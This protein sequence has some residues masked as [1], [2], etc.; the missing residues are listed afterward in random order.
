MLFADLKGSMEL[1]AQRDPEEARKLLDPVL[2]HMMEAVH[3]YEGTVNQVMGDGIM[4]LFGAPVAHEDHAVRACYAAL[5]M[6]ESVKRYAEE[7]QLTVGVPIHIRV[8]LNSGEVVVRSIGSDLR[9]DYTAVGQT[10]HLAARME[11]LAR[12]GTT[13]I[14]ADT[15]K[16]TEGYLQ[17]QSL[18]AIPIKGLA[19]AVEVFELVGGGATRRR[20]EAAVARGLSRFLGRQIELAIL[21]QALERARTGHGQI[22]APVGE[23][24][25]GKSRLFWEFTHSHRTEGCLV[26]ESGSVSY[27]KATLYLP[28]IDL[29]KVYLQ[30]EDRDDSR[31]IREK[32]T[33]KLL[34]LD[35]ALEPLLSA[36][37]ALLDVPVDDPQWQT[38]DPP[39]RRQRTLEAVK[40][41]LLRES[42]VQ[43]LVVV[44]EDIHWIDSETQAV[45]DS[46][47]ESLPGARVL[48]LVNYRPEYQHTWGSK[49]YYMQLRLD[50][51]PP[52]S[53]EELLHALLGN[54][55]ALQPLKRLLIA[56]TEGNPFFLEE[57][58]R[59]LI[60]T[61]VLV[62]QCGEYRL[63]RPLESIQVPATV[64]AVLAAWIDQLPPQEK[65]L[66]ETAAVI[67]KDVPFALLQA[68]A[69]MPEVALRRGL[70]HL[71]AAEFLYETALFPELEYTFKHAL[72][73]E[74]AYGS[75]LQER[76]RGVHALIVG[77][78]ER[79]YPD[80]LTEQIERLA[81]HVLRG[82]VWEKAVTYLHKAGR[83][84]AARWGNREAVACFKQTLVAL[85]HLPRSREMI[86]KA[87]DLR[88]DLR[89]ALHWLG[90]F[91]QILDYLSEAETLAEDLG[92]QRRLER[93]TRYR[94]NQFWRIG[95]PDRAIASGQ[96]ALAISTA[97]GDFGLQVAANYLLGG[98]YHAQGGYRRAMDVFRQNVASL[99]GELLYER[100]GQT[101]IISVFSRVYLVWCLA[102]CG[103]FDEGIAHGEEA[104]QIA[105]SVDQPYSLTAA[106]L[107]VG[108][109][110]LR[111]GDF[112]KAIPI[113]ERGLT[114]CRNAGVSIWL[115]W[116]ALALGY[117]YA[118][119]GRVA[120]GVPLLEHAVERAASMTM[121]VEQ[122]LRLAWLSE[123]HLLA[124]QMEDAVPLAV[125]AL[126]L[127]RNHKEQGYEAWAHRLLG[128]SAA[129]S[130]PTDV[131]KAEN[132]YREA[133]ALA[134]ELDMRP[135]VAHC[136]LGLGRLHRRLGDR[137]T[138]EEHLTSAT[139]LFREMGMQ[140]WLD[141]AEKELKELG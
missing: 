132:Y 102:E 64:R 13:L 33:N 69:G 109:L 56:R 25:I 124:G 7:V 45:L 100:F 55:S 12:P 92:D 78:M 131:E 111:K 121:M 113:L 95:S 130:D 40:R 120:E 94:C 103:E 73:H 114:L 52:E 58:V 5:W 129:H 36:L 35:R 4:A 99:K 136:H 107:C 20:F 30:I 70:T 21:G 141:P 98:A 110:Y 127:A 59:A 88:F 115:L 122:S 60:E 8:G 128:E 85:E 43:P 123:S 137:L 19:D 51:L 97:L 105:E 32:V 15:L 34:T 54:E 108:L 38:L 68:I 117:T 23:A 39:Q 119:V 104:V 84:A 27:G 42:Q 116:G 134:N 93:I 77:A 1:L 53:V 18:G 31:K 67:G 106:Y 75:L 62:G 41:L 26:L 37:L 48:L 17:V 140:F 133:M 125:R 57:S 65:T 24:G 61:N 6:Q 135:L 126:N 101:G 81:H 89:I 112:Q 46:L 44:M 14:T 2:E 90:E 82:E 66:L 80:R 50:P 139:A 49:T 9:M 96:R 22:V 118:L 87:I 11:Q 138:A 83:K 47:V 71:Q 16:L 91:E 63:A 79:L 76:R 29:L 28:V 10:T 86:E 74:V 3:R 72:T